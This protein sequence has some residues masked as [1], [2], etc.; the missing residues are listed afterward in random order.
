MVVTVSTDVLMPGHLPDSIKKKDTGLSGPNLSD[1]MNLKEARE[2]MEYEMIKRAVIQ[3][4]S[5]RK[6]GQL[7][8]INHSTV[9]RK[10]KRCG[11]D[12]QSAI[13]QDKDNPSLAGP[14][15]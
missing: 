3:T 1:T 7:L 6:A 8:G 13:S 5:A 10:A 14:G 2:A 11:L 15:H 4:G 9:L 12:I